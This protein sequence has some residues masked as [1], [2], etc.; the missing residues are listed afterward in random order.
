MFIVHFSLVQF[1]LASMNSPHNNLQ[2][3]VRELKITMK[4]EN[5]EKGTELLLNF[6]QDK[7]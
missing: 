5:G 1:I 6:L 4:Q 7:I 2:I 3:K